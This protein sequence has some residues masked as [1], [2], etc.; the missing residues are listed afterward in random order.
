MFVLMAVRCS[1]RPICSAML[2]KRC[3]KMESWMGSS[4]VL[5]SLLSLFSTSI[6]TLPKRVTVATQFGFT[7]I[8]VFLSRMM[9]G[10]DT[11][12]PASKL[13]NTNTRVSTY[14]LASAKYTGTTYT[15]AGEKREKFEIF[16]TFNHFPS[17]IFN[18]KII[19]QFFQFFS[20]LSVFLISQF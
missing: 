19:F 12:W 15:T 10:P 2:M 9:A 3:P 6:I 7:R 14:L 17:K 11:T 18:S 13:E 4:V 5:T 8:V 16:D 20:I 1:T